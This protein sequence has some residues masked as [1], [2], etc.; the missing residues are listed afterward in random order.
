MT[1]DELERAVSN[2]RPE[3][4]HA[5]SAWFDAFRERAWDREIEHDASTGKLDALVARAREEHRAGRTR[6]L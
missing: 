4:L 2:L 5:F 1:I 3:E 6:P